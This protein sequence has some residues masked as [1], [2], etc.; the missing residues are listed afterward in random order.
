[1]NKQLTLFFKEV[2]VINYANKS[3]T[4]IIASFFVIVI[5]ND[6][7]IIL[8]YYY[9]LPVIYLKLSNWLNAIIYPAI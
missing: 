1:M 7:A 4:F 5:N 2:G 3:I 8:S 6:L 9:Q